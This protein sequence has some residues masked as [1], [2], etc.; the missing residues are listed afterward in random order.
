MPEIQDSK[1]DSQYQDYIMKPINFF[2]LQAKHLKSDY[3]TQFIHTSNKEYP[4]YDYKPKFININSFVVDFD[5]MEVEAEVFTLQKAQHVIAM[6]LGF[7]C[8]AEFIK[9]PI[10]EQ[11]LLIN[12]YK[13]NVNIHEWDTQGLDSEAQVAIMYYYLEND[14]FIEKVDYLIQEF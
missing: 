5:Y 9:A 2:K 7:N 3:K 14:S 1:L 8:W 11:E 13:N 10:E 12:L 4:V 6:I